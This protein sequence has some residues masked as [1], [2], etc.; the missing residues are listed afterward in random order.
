MDTSICGI[1][2]RGASR[3]GDRFF[4]YVRELIR[5]P[6]AVACAAPYTGMRCVAFFG[7]G[8]FG[9]NRLIAVGYRCGR[10]ILVAI[11]ASGTGMRCVTFRLTGRF[12]N[13]IFVR[14]RKRFFAVGFVALLTIYA[15]VRRKPLFRTGRRSY[16]AVIPTMFAV[17]RNGARDFFGAN[18]ASVCINAR[19]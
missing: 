5:F 9:N 3:R 19:A 10:R 15:R 11:T 8:R 14:M 7:T 6:V 4:V 18:L 16:G 12:G 17:Y 1:S 2:F 13:D